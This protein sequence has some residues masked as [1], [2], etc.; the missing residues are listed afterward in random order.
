M[1]MVI[2]KSKLKEVANGCNVGSDFAEALNA[3][4]VEEVK[5][6]AHR[7][8]ANSRKT[9][10]ARDVFVGDVKA[11]EMLV[12]KSKAKAAVSDKFNVSGDF[13]E[14]LNEV[15]VAMVGQA[16]ARAQANGRKTLGARDL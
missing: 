9:V 12:S 5:K 4:V 3:A 15:V 7:A 16:A 8:E 6:A 10:Q 11:K 13:A 1:E 14:A 2:V